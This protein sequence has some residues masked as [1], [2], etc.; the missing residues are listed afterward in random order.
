MYEIF[1]GG[2][3]SES[4]TAQLYGEYMFNH[5]DSSQSY[6]TILHSQKQG[7]GVPVTQIFATTTWY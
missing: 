7:T 2:S 1:Y 3:I 6:C 4:E 5:E